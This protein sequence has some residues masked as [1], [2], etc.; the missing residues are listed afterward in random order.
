MS[1]NPPELPFM[2]TVAYACL[3]NK[4]GIEQRWQLLDAS[5]QVSLQAMKRV[6]SKALHPWQ[7]VPFV[8]TQHQIQR[9][10]NCRLGQ[11]RR[12]QN[13]HQIAGIHGWLSPEP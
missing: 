3:L 10:A 2:Q 8:S 1:Q 5:K 4:S 7:Q 12:G 13:T 11:H 6:G 9:S